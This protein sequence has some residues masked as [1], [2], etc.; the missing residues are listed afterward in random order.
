MRNMMC[1]VRK[2]S[3]KDHRL[4]DITFFVILNLIT[5]EKSVMTEYDWIQIKY[6]DVTRTG[7]YTTKIQSFT[8]H[9]KKFN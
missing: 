1:R 4:I 5:D 2:A 6:F 7:K 8:V 9:V 3:C